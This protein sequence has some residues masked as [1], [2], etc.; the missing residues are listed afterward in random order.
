MAD[1]NEIKTTFTV[2]T[3]TSS[4]N[5][6]RKTYQTLGDDLDNFVSRIEKA[7]KKQ[8]EMM[9]RRQRDLDFEKSVRA[10]TS[11]ESGPTGK[12]GGSIG[13][14]GFGKLESSINALSGLSNGI[15][16]G[17]IIGAADGILDL[18]QGIQE[19]PSAFSSILSFVNPLTAGLAGVGIAFA[20][21]SAQTAENA[22]K[23]QARI[24]ANRSASDLVASGATS[25]QIQEQIRGLERRLE[26]EEKL[27]EQNKRAYQQIEDQGAVFST[28]AKIFDQSEEVLS[29]S[30]GE[31]SDKVLKYEEEIRALT[32]AMESAEVAANNYA[33]SILEQS[34]L[35]K[36]AILTEFEANER[37][38][39][40]NRERLRQI[41]VQIEAT[42]AQLAIL[43][44]AETQS[45]ETTAK[46]AELEAQLKALGQEADITGR[47]TEQ[48]AKD[49]S[50]ANKKRED[51]TKRQI[52]DE[53]RRLEEE[54]RKRQQEAEKQAQALQ[55]LNDKIIDIAQKRAD[56]EEDLQRQL[57]DSR[58]DARRKL[59]SDLKALDEKARS[60]TI[61]AVQAFQADEA[62]QARDHQRNL[63]QIVEDANRQ[64]EGLERDLDFSGLFDLEA[65]TNQAL[66][67]AEAQF[68]I[69]QSERQIAFDQQLRDLKLSLSDE[70][71]ARN[72]A[73]RDELADISRN[74][75]RARRD[76][77]IA[78]DRELRDAQAQYDRMFEVTQGGLRKITDAIDRELNGNRAGSGSG[79]GTPNIPAPPRSGIGFAPVSS[80][81]SLF[82]R[83]SSVVNN[84]GGISINV[85]G[86]NPADV[87][88]A[89]LNGIKKIF[90]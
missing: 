23:L 74:A 25:S 56:A 28:F 32:E 90:G 13:G 63:Q 17:S 27:L 77:Q 67:D 4:V 36:Q 43:K 2:E 78:F 5:K 71:Q 75:D 9:Q 80:N 54:T 83:S 24:D 87:E 62:K 60:E 39:E 1:N 89:V 59:D 50:D 73:F 52:E 19:L 69:E 84:A 42:Q 51:E 37:T 11:F 57:G 49:I 30:I 40:Q 41:N 38:A 68:Q 26:A 29:A 14:A 3:D 64:R 8:R 58:S 46:I 48:T 72:Q 15:D 86:G 20:I 16:A 66:S 70:R 88:R 47:F 44:N 76:K 21:L 6:A 22:E 85:N 33:Q 82:S 65:N 53:N 79:Q 81:S 31:S 45:A 35:A 12:A 34:E 55:A 61:K 18:S 7:D 10:Q